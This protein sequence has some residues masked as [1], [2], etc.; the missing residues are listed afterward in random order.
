[1]IVEKILLYLFIIEFVTL[2]AT[3]GIILILSHVFYFTPIFHSLKKAEFWIYKC[4]NKIIYGG[5]KKG[6]NIKIIKIEKQPWI[7]AGMIRCGDPN[8][9]MMHSLNDNKNK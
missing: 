1:M 5:D 9:K 2:F 8:C 3:R 7:E 4:M 6:R